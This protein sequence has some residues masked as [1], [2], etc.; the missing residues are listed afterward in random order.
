MIPEGLSDAAWEAEFRKSG[1]DRQFNEY[2]AVRRLRIALANLAREMT[3]PIF[4]LL[5]RLVTS[6]G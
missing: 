1:R 5:D 2:I 3:R 6:R 4:R